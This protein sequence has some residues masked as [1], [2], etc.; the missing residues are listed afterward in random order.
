MTEVLAKSFPER[1]DGISISGKYGPGE[2]P[3]Y[4]LRQLLRASDIQVLFPYGEAP[5][6][7]FGGYTFSSEEEQYVRF[8][9]MQS[10]FLESIK[11]KPYHIV[12]SDSVDKDG[13][14]REGYVGFST[15]HE[16]GEAIAQEKPVVVTHTIQEIS[17]FVPQELFDIIHTRERTFI[18]QN[19]FEMTTDQ[20]KDFL[21]RLL[22][23]VEYG[24]K[25]EE[26]DAIEYANI[27]LGTIELHRWLSW[28]KQVRRDYYNGERTSYIKEP[29]ESETDLY[30]DRALYL[31]LIEALKDEA[32]MKYIS[33]TD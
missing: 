29:L 13:V 17:Q 22:T 2:Q 4:K 25:Q 23:R 20:I 7:H 31:P 27:R 30:L 8:A 14:R 5:Q 19:L 12:C 9:F 15:A 21:G 1:L 11:A 26:R 3:V 6:E 33:R 18:S 16:I 32:C 28:V 10:I 24:L